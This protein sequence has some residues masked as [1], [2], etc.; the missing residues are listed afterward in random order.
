MVETFPRA[1]LPNSE[2]RILYSQITRRSYR[3]DVLLP[4]SYSSSQKT[5]PVIYL[6]DGDFTTGLASSLT[7]FLHFL[8][9]TPE[10]IVASIQLV[11]EPNED[12]GYLREIEFKVPGV[13]DAPPES[14]ANLFLSALEQE[15]LPL[16]ETAYRANPAER[17]LYGY[18]SSGFFTLYALLS[19]PGL[20][21]TYLAGSPD[22][23]LSNPYWKVNDQKL[24]SRPNPA[25]IDLFLTVGGLE[26][27]R[28]QSSYSTF[29]ELLANIQ[30]KNYPGLRLVSEVYPH[31][32]HGSVGIALTYLNGLR[33]C[34]PTVQQD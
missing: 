34:F 11:V 27:G 10:V 4:N 20:F 29:R 17:I 25:P 30:A 24:L 8:G 23:D 28:Y 33:Q 21:R 5:Y 18:S 13:Q 3:I 1:Q 9:T 2:E 19:L 6:L 7:E 16:V 31:E 22:T 26:N 15:I 12:F 14:H 32:D